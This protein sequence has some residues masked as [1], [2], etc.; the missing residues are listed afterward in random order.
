MVSKIGFIGAGKMGSA[1]IE[2][3]VG[4]GK[5]KPDQIMVYDVDSKIVEELR[6]KLGIVA[7]KTIG[8]AVTSETE[9]IILAVKPQVMRQVLESIKDLVE[10]KHLLISIA[11]GKTTEFMLSIVGESAR[12]IRVM[13]NAA[14]MVGKGA[15]GL[16]AGGQA[17]KKDLDIAVEIFNE[18]GEA[19]IVEE[20]V[21]DVVTALSGSGPGYLF[22]MMEALVDGAVQ[23]GMDRANARK[24]AVQTFAGAAAMAAAGD[25]PFSEL[26]DRITSPGGTTIAG[27]Q[28]MEREGIRGILI[29]T[30]E[31][32]TLRGI[33]LADG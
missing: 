14:A 23:M 8:D 17:D 7:A 1:L 21:M 2:G 25:V 33:K 15:T 27:L 24:L 11:A 29:D 18:V 28:V 20:K 9:I 16:C 31:A 19:V 3:L 13:P 26:K 4:S 32:A 5:W 6:H 30:I 12:V 22:V 10:E